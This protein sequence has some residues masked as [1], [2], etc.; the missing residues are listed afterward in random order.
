MPVK[1][2]TSLLT[3]AKVHQLYWETLI[4]WWC[5][6]ITFRASSSANYEHPLF[7]SFLKLL[8]TNIL[9]KIITEL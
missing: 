4:I 1:Q 6:E 9:L 3:P 2:Y 7:Y 5:T 8:H